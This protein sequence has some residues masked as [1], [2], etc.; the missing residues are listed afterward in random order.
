M[1]LSKYYLRFYDLAISSIRLL[2]VLMFSNLF[3]SYL[4][5]E[6]LVTLEESLY[7]R[8]EQNHMDYILVFILFLCYIAYVV[9][10]NIGRDFVRL[11]FFRLMGATQYLGCSKILRLASPKSSSYAELI[12][13]CTTDIEKVR[14]ALQ[15]FVAFFGLIPLQ[16]GSVVFLLWIANEAALVGLIVLLLVFPILVN[17]NII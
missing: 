5:Y 6:L 14:D 3:Q 1:R 4:F 9:F 13:Y 11:N 12:T 8:R 17:L 7:G 2:N 10:S 15:L 16:I